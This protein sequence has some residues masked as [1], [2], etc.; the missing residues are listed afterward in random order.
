[1]ARFQ[2]I[3]NLQ[4]RGTIWYWSPRMPPGFLNPTLTGSCHSALDNR[5]ITEPA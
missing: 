1:M 4:R 2:T 5:I 3:H